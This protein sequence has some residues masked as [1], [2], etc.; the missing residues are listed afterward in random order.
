M[1]QSHGFRRAGATVALGS[2]LGFGVA[3][4]LTPVLSRLVSPQV[5][6]NFM[7]V[8][9]VAALLTGVS[10]LRLEILAQAYSDERQARTLRLALGTMWVTSA[11]VALITVVGWVMGVL[12]PR[13]LWVAP[14]VALGSWQLVG[15]A[16]LVVAGQYRSLAVA[17]FVQGSSTGVAQVGLAAVSPAMWA[18]STGVVAGRLV[19][20]R[21]LPSLPRRHEVVSTWLLNRARAVR[22]GSSALINSTAGQVQILLPALLYGPVA[23]G[24]FAMAVRLLPAPLMV[25][26][27]AMAA[28]AIGEV[29]R[30]LRDQDGRTRSIVRRGLRDLFILGIL[31][32]VAVAVLA[33][34]VTGRLLGERWEEVGVILAVLSAGVLAQFCAA[35]FS[36]VLNLTGHSGRLLVWDV[37]RLVALGGAF[38]AP[39]VMGQPLSVAAGVYSVTLVLLYVFLSAL[40]LGAVRASGGPSE[41]SSHDE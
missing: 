26:S 32:C 6:G 41:V 18:L 24:V 10:T 19:W 22:A 15:S 40:V 7:A 3:L 35:P 36:Q 33:P 14:M 29:G 20:W 11:I 16:R 30:S 4:A 27:Q 5:F 38:V 8:V 28:A 25:I 23:A 37:T 12:E 31:P 39:S 17:N 9:A 13:W 21:H 1:P 2:A 34:F